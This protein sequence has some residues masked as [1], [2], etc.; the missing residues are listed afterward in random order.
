M[1]KLKHI[2]GILYGV[3]VGDALG[4]PV[5]FKG[6]STIALNPVIDMIGYGTYNLPEGTWSDDSSMTFCLAEAIINSPKSTLNLSMLMDNFWKWKY[7]NFWTPRGE[8]FD[9]GMATTN[10]IDRWSDKMNPILCGGQSL[11]SNGNGSLMRILPLLLFI[12][13][14]SMIGR[15]LITK[16]VSSLTHAH[17]ISVI[18]CFYYL[19]FA[20]LLLEGVDKFEAYKTLKVEVTEFFETNNIGLEHMREMDRLLDGDVYEFPLSMIK[21]SGYVINTLEASIW[22]ILNTDSYDEAVLT[23]VNMGDDTDTTAAVTGGLAGILYGFKN[24]RKSWV[25]S[26][27]RKE[28]IDKL[29]KRLNKKLKK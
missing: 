20:R 11:S 6:R 5:E 28:D 9:I 10:A 18:S 14:E 17:D 1:I 7:E 19:E 25:D 2:K 8:V 21:S 29:C 24:I 15:Y 3:A 27:A 12:K 16:N 26:L 13:D 22:A 23:A 4:V